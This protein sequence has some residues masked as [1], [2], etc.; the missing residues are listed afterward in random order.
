MLSTHNL[1][2]AKNSGATE[3]QQKGNYPAESGMSIKLIIK[4]GAGRIVIPVAV[5]ED[6]FHPAGFLK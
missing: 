6:I 3:N 5:D 2:P 1:F 4:N